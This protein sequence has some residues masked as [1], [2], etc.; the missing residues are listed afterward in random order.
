MLDD[1]DQAWCCRPSSFLPLEDDDGNLCVV[2]LAHE[3]DGDD[4]RHG[5]LCVV[6]LAQ[7]HHLLAH[8][9]DVMIMVMSMI[10]VMPIAYLS[11]HHHLLPAGARE[12]ALVALRL[13]QTQ[14]LSEEEREK[15]RRKMRKG[16]KHDEEGAE[17]RKT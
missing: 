3:S 5:N 10:V 2:F 9:D 12:L 4:G 14:L 11:Q 13:A 8:D 1:Y 7:H 17:R 16:G 6:Y 15:I